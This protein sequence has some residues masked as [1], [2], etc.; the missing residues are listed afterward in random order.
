MQL[1]RS[2]WDNDVSVAFSLIIVY[3][4][5]IP[6]LSMGFVYTAVSIARILLGLLCLA[7]LR[8]VVGALLAVDRGRRAP[9]ETGAGIEQSTPGK[10][11]ATSVTDP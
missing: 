5:Y 6:T 8:H 2:I 7:M 3:V 4:H 1:S 11:S 9:A 10:S